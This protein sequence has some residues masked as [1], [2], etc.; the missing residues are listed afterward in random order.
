MEQNKNKL[1]SRVLFYTGKS[2][3]CCMAKSVFG[4][5]PLGLAISIICLNLPLAMLILFNVINFEFRNKN[6]EIYI[7]L[8]KLDSIS[9]S[10]LLHMILLF[11]FVL[12]VLSNILIWKTAAKDPGI[13]PSRLWNF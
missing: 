10:V 7:D 2:K 11:A 9:Y 3:V 12:Q 4:A 6:G 13:I 5:T 8:L 1:Y